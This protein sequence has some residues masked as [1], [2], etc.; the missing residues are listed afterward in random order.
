VGRAVSLV[1]T[2]NLVPLVLAIVFMTL[3][4]RMGRRSREIP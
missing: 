2:F 1:Y 4:V 3:L